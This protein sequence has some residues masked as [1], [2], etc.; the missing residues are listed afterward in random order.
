MKERPILFSTA[1]IP[2]ILRDEKTH[3]SRVIKPQPRPVQDGWIWKDAGFIGVDAF[4]GLCPFG[5]PGERL[6]VKETH[7]QTIDNSHNDEPGIAY[8]E[9]ADRLYP[10]HWK[11]VPSIHMPRWASRITLEILGIEARRLQDISGCEILREGVNSHVHLGADYFNASQQE[12][13]EWLWDSLNAKPKPAGHNPYTGEREI[14]YVSYPWE[15]T[16]KKH[17][18][19]RNVW[20]VVGNPWIWDVEFKRAE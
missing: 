7:Y 20:Y 16:Q 12:C 19:K 17:E 5:Q 18:Y 11:K 8:I 3:T 13:F 4:R 15:D 14:C 1:M 6:W 10:G 2:P 9:D